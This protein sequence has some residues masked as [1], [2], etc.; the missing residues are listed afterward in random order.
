MKTTAKQVT[1]AIQAYIVESI[2]VSGY[3][4]NKDVS[5]LKNGLQIIVSEFQHAAIYDNNLKRF[6]HN[7]QAIFKDWM[8][9]LPSCLS[10]EFSNYGILEKMAQFGLPLPANKTEEEGIELYYYLIYRELLKLL[11]ANNIDIHKPVKLF[12]A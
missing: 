5:E 3:G 1:S 6:K 9:G 10:I 12:Q 4:V 8:Q 7:Y 11:K 2:E